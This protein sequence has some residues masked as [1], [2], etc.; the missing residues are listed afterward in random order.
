VTYGHTLT[1]VLANTLLILN[2]K[3]GVLK[4]SVAA[5]I[6]G[7]A[8]TT[9]RRVLAVDLDQQ[10]NL[11]RDLGYT[12]LS[13]GG[14]GLLDAISSGVPLIPIRNV[15]PNLDVIAAGPSTNRLYHEVSAAA[16][17]SVVPTFDQLA[18]VLAPLA[19]GYDLI[20]ID[21]PPGGE[22][23]HLVAMTAAR[24]V[25]IPT[26]PDQGSIDGLATVFRSMLSVRRATNPTVDI[27][28]VVLGPVSSS[29]TRLR[30]DTLARLNVD[31]GGKAHVFNQTIRNCQLAAVHCR[32]MG[33]LVHEYASAAVVAPR[34]YEQPPTTNGPAVRSYSQAAVGLADD[35]KKLVGEILDRFTEQSVAA[36]LHAGAVSVDLG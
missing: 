4:T 19:A 29:A 27:L 21:S 34:W 18:R 15:R 30:A 35:Y 7:I 28:G 22:S 1:G 6:A 3:G 33:Q 20:V 31:L 16:T 32:E 10:A 26:Q 13:D 23:L 25:V 12:A 14:R 9:G 5:Q 11:A 8:A 24:F 2:G 36:A 17:G